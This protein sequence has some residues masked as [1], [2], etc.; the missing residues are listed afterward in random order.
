M[1]RHLLFLLA[2]IITSIY[3]S[4]QDKPQVI[5]TAYMKCQYEY[6]YLSDTIT[7]KTKEDL[8]I[9]RVGHKLSKC[10][11]MYSERVDS[12][13]AL[14]NW[15]DIMHQALN[16][17]LAPG[18]SGVNYPHKRMKEY[19]YK[20]Y[21]EVKMTVTDGIALQ[22]YLYEDS[23]NAQDWEIKD[24]SKTVLGYNCMM[25]ECDFR[26]RHWTAWFATDIPIMDGPW[27]PCGLPGLI[28]EAYSGGMQNHF[29]IIGLQKVDSE[30]IFFSPS[31]IGNKK[32]ERTT[33]KK[34]QRLR[35]KDFYNGLDVIQIETGI[36]LSEGVDQRSKD[37]RRYDLEE[38]DYR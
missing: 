21:P 7:G 34:F 29:V 18:A 17:A 35:V 6:N 9:L 14:P 24:S 32:Y 12:I 10:T 5:D 19:V 36:D 30:Q 33:R 22:S 23:L 27:K 1:R 8:L 4:A 15:Y 13:F 11:S 38:R 20:N 31:Y 2:F 28:M 3:S 16:K 25:A 37:V 26:S